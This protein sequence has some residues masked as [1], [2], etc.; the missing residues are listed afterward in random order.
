MTQNAGRSQGS[1]KLL[2]KVAILCL[3][4][5]FSFSRLTGDGTLPDNYHNPHGL[6]SWYGPGFHGRLTAN[7][8]RFNK[9]ANTAA[10]KTLRLG[11]R[12]CVTNLDNGKSLIVRINDRGPFIRGRT[13]DLSEGV[14][15]KLGMKD[16]GLQR[17]LI[18]KECYDNV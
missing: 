15:I 16:K 7:G 18:T 5:L 17:V 11:T 2:V 6:A 8:E 1:R 14:A 3:I 10:H 9:H 12:V 13:I 4:G